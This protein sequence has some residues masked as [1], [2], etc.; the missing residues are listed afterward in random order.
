MGLSNSK[1]EEIIKKADKN[2][3]IKSIYIQGA[4]EGDDAT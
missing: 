2:A 4:M 3:V 1:V